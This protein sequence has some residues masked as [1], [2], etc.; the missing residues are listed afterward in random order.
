MSELELGLDTFG[1]VSADTAGEHLSQASVLRNV[2][3]EAI[4][5]DSLGVDFFGVG[6]HHR[7]DFA[8]SCPE[9]VLGAIAARTNRIRL[10]SAVTVLSS[11]DPIRVFQ[12][13]S[14]VDAV[15]NGRAEV[16]LGR[17]AFVES[18]P[19]FGYDLSNHDSLFEDKLS[20][21][22][23]LAT[24]RPVHWEG[25]FRPPLK[26]MQV[27]PQPA[28]GMLKTWIGVGGSPASVVRAARYG[29][30]LML[31]IIGGDP[32]RFRPFVDLYERACS[33]AGRS[34]Q[35]IG[36]HSPGYVAATDQ[37]ARDELWPHYK[38]LRDRI[39]GA[40][41]RPPLQR[42]EFDFEADHGS[43]YVGSPETVAA[44]I[45]KTVRS[46]HISRFQM[47]YSAGTLSHEHLMQSIELFGSKVIP[48]VRRIIA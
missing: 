25:D 46:L 42:S 44:K 7:D 17:G 30:S 15:S 48:I 2:V 38:K 34:P 4:R 36:V 35:S 9:V 6:E 45:A 8:I 33:E 32:G 14:T 20:L 19:L 11:D 13:F 27:F 41:G 47:R 31:A 43:L 28:S 29:M 12:R 40:R 21:F 10:G 18:F 16:I 24:D 23:R 5:A 39:D 26:G 37:Q 1:D 3:E 22:S